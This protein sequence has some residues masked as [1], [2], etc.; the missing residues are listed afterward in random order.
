MQKG[1]KNV[2]ATFRISKYIESVS[3]QVYVQGVFFNWSSPKNHK[4]GKKLKYQNWSS[5]KNHKYG[6]KVKVPESWKHFTYQKHLELLGG[7]QLTLR[8]FMG[9]PVRK[10]ETF[11]LPKNT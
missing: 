1:Q 10:L 5:P 3:Q 9:G 8:N 7:D 6:K 11:Y 4:Y 2:V